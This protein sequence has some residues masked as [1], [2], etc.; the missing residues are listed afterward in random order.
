MAYFAKPIITEVGRVARIYYV[1]RNQTA[2]W[3]THR[4]E[5]EL[6]LLTGWC[7]I[8]KHG[9]AYQM[10]MKTRS[11]AIRHCWYVLV[12]KAEEPGVRKRT[13]KLAA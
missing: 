9:D 8:A 13:L 2:A 1:D 7:W 6:R 12:H 5:G 11:A 3:N 10:G 4:R